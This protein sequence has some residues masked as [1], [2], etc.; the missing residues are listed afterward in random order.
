MSHL[1]IPGF[2]QPWESD[3]GRPNR[4]VSAFTIMRDGPIGAAAFNN[5]FGR[6][7]L[8]GYFRAFETDHDGVRW[9]YHKPIM[10]AGGYGNVRPEHVIKRG[11]QPGYSL[12]AL[13]LSLI[14][15]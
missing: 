2:E 3:Y 11:I 4:I 9:G 12:I 7:N 14:H 8:C 6:P 15:I 10:I 1:R 13:G 5:E